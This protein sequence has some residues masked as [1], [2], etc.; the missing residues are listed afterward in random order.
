MTYYILLGG[1]EHLDFFE[2]PSSYADETWFW[3][4]PKT[5]RV[6]DTAFVYLCA[7][8]SRIVGQFEIAG[9]PLYNHGWLSERWKNNWMAEIGNVT[10]FEPRPELTIKGLREL[11]PDWGWL[12]YPRNKVKIPTEIVKPFL[13]L[14]Q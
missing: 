10:Y 6:G 4:V 3:T 11:F 9:E 12:R 1:A 14:V 7:P 8:V 2:S 5:A 13:E